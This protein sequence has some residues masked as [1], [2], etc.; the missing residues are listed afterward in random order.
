MEDLT[1]NAGSGDDE[2]FIS[3]TV[4]D[5]TVH[6]G[7]GDDLIRV[8]RIVGF[9]THTLDSILGDLTV[10]AGG[11]ANDSL[12]LR[13]S[14]EASGHTYWVSATT[15]KRSGAAL[16]TYDGAEALGVIA[17]NFDDTFAVFG[18]AAITATTL[19]R[20]GR[21]RRLHRRHLQQAVHIPLDAVLGPLTI[22]GGDGSG[23][24]LTLNDKAGATGKEYLLTGTHV[25]WVGGTTI[26]YSSLN[27]LTLNA[28]DHGDEITVEGTAAATTVNA[29]GGD[30]RDRGHAR[31]EEPG[32]RQR[33]DRR[34]RRRG[35]RD[36]PERPEQPVRR[37]R[38]RPRLHRHRRACG[39]VVH[40]RAVRAVLPLRRLRRGRDPE[41][42][43]GRRRETSSRSRARPPR[44]R[45]IG[46]GGDDTVAVGS[47]SQHA[48]RPARP[49]RS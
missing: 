25:T 26:I 14:G 11:G 34:C 39:P 16:I 44:T 28:T 43:R 36:D 10:H 13:D 41:P 15:V 38:A 21:R 18:T 32:V 1:V 29:N 22:D 20:P 35:R 5:T 42:V 33:A 8:G 7:L 49:A 19:E 40:G 12:L 6:A 3:R 37:R 30:G 48:R 31:V 46:G 45:V 24:S 23:D 47:A 27:S 2:F 4:A 17:G 9:N